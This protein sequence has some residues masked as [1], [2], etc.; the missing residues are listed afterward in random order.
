MPKTHRHQPEPLLVSTPQTEPI[1]LATITAVHG[2]RGWVK[3]HLRNEYSENI[4][5]NSDMCYRASSGAWQTLHIE[6]AKPHKR[7]WIVRIRDC[8]DRD[9]AE[10]YVGSTLALAAEQLKTLKAGEYYWYQLCGLFVWAGESK[11]S[12][13]LLGRIDHLF[14]TGANDVMVVAPCANGK[15]RERV[16]IPWVPA[17]VVNEVNLDEGW[18]RVQWEGES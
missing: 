16:L 5:G 9:I 1:P 17:N 13:V 8:E 7:G 3:L 18:L 12:A 11:E 6:E 15:N 10:Q 14:A 4:K 2:V